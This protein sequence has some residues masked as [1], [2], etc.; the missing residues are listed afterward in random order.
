MP[1]ARLRFVGMRPSRAVRALASDRTIR[2][3]GAVPDV[4]PYLWNAAV[5]VA[6]LWMARGVQN[7]VLEAVAAGLPAVVTPPVF[8]GLPNRSVPPASWRAIRTVVCGNG[9]VVA[10]VTAD[11]RR[12]IAGRADLSG[13]TWNAQLLSPLLDVVE[14]AAQRRRL[15]IKGLNDARDIRTVLAARIR[16]DGAIDRR[17]DASGHA[18]RAVARRLIRFVDP[19]GRFACGRV[20]LRREWP[21]RIAETQPSTAV[22]IMLDG[23]IYD[24]ADRRRDLE[25]EGV[26]F[27]TTDHAELLAHGLDRWGEAFFTRIEGYF[28][29]AI[30]DGA[31]REPPA[32]H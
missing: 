23:E 22:V 30:W 3:T 19:A 28:S 6:P 26:S 18:S 13:L 31:D 7:K 5:S 25:S 1:G 16:T 10:A 32:H 21:R 17:S 14:A 4:R 12:R 11:G 20:S 9:D 15:S 24:Y 29:A 27:A 8:D 2:V